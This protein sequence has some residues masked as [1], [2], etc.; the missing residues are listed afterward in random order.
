MGSTSTPPAASST[1]PPAVLELLRVR[2]LARVQSA[3]AC[4][5]SRR[6]VAP[7][8]LALDDAV[9]ADI[10]HL[11]AR[12]P[13]TRR[14]QASLVR[15]LI[16]DA[17]ASGANDRQGRRRALTFTLAGAVFPLDDVVSLWRARKP[18]A[19]KDVL[20]SARPALEQR[21]LI[22]AEERRI[23][24]AVAAR[25]HLSSAELLARRA[26]LDVQALDK[27]IDAALAASASLYPASDIFA[28]P[29]VERIDDNARA[30]AAASAAKVSADP[31]FLLAA[32]DAGFLR[33]A[34]NRAEALARGASHAVSMRERALA[35]RAF[36]DGGDVD[37]AASHILSDGAAPVGG[38]SALL[39]AADGGAVVD[40]FIAALRAPALAQEE[41]SGAPLDDCRKVWDEAGPVDELGFPEAFV[42]VMKAL[43]ELSHT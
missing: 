4:A 30:S 13:I 10:L 25:V 20:D 7:P 24:D 3:F 35:V 32:S 41:W 8:A 37:V 9:A 14:A 38:A 28:L 39:P 34:R 1:V 29:E 31:I 17:L 42:D 22:D 23:V 5:T 26:G 16:E 2:D 19:R 36:K 27:L 43:P 15:A 6:C 11:A 18:A 40:A 21:A 12:D 33:G